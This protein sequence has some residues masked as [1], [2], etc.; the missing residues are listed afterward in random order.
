MA[1][2]NL[3][4]AGNVKPIPVIHFIPPV[5]IPVWKIEIITDTETI[6]ITELIY[7]GEFSDGVTN[8]IGDF[9]L[10]LIDPSNDLTDRIEDFDT[11][12]IYLDYGKTATTLRFVGKIERRSNAEN[13]WLDISGRSIGMLTTGTNIT[14][15]S[16]GLKAR[17]TILTEIIDKLNT[18]GTKKYFDGEISS[19]G[20]ESDTGTMDVNYS[21]IPFWTIVQEICEAGGRDAYIDV[22]QSF[23]YFEKGSRENTTEAVVE[24]MNLIDTE[25][26][27]KDTQEIVTKVRVYGAISGSVPIISSSDSNTTNTKGIIKEQKID[28]ASALTPY[29]TKGLADAQAETYKEA[30]TVG[31]V[32]SVLTPTILPGEKLMITNPVNN[33]PPAYYEINS[34]RHMFIED[35]IPQTVF[36]IKKEKLDS[37]ILFKKQ[38]K[39]QAESTNNI[40]SEDMDNTII[41]DY[42]TTVGDTLFDLGT[43]VNTEIEVDSN[44]IG[45]LKTKSGNIGTWTSKEILTSALMSKVQIKYNSTYIG[46]TKFFISLDKGSTYVEIGSLAGDFSFPNAQNSIIIRVDIKSTDTR[47]E[48]IGIYYK[49]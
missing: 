31:T 17:S 22:D 43:H 16:S 45:S 32:I 11:V 34:Y 1:V 39:F 28:N 7:N 23:N 40:N 19:A 26:Y 4:S 36:T 18:D 42:N 48:K 5:F 20:I 14:Y 13:I 38:F 25:D 27:A 47:I 8:S 41:Y 24:N 12:K 46:S 21:E 15:N 10:R 44:G 9:A 6:D 3:H 29:Q 2:R 33:I 30:P 37:A 35:G 49:V